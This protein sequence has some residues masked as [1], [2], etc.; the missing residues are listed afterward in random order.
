MKQKDEILVNSIEKK[1][2]SFEYTKA[3]MRQTSK[4]MSFYSFTLNFWLW[5]S[6]FSTQTK[7]NYTCK[8]AKCGESS[9][10][11]RL[12][13]QNVIKRM[14]W[15]PSK[16]HFWAHNNMYKRRTSNMKQDTWLL[17][18]LWFYWPYRATILIWNPKIEFYIPNF[19]RGS[20]MKRPIVVNFVTYFCRLR[21]N[22]I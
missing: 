3:V 10:T 20:G 6:I 14:K 21:Q 13:K 8:R 4:P 1:I 22:S 5:I 11:I 15:A 18:L 9:K 2:K 12:A 19:F 7:Q 16:I 17:L